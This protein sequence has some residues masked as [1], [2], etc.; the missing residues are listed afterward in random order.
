MATVDAA[1][2]WLSLDGRVLAFEEHTARFARAVEF[3]GGDADAARAAM[4]EAREAT[5]DSGAFFPRVDFAEGTFTHRIRPNPQ[6]SESAV[7][8]TAPT[9]PRTMPAVKGP[10]LSA[11]AALNEQ[12]R[13]AG[14][15]E[16]VLLSF[17]GELIEA[18]FSALCWWRG[19]TLCYPDEDLERIDSVTW[20]TVRR[21]AIADGIPMSPELAVPADLAGTEVWVMNARH[22]IRAVTSWVDGPTL[23]SPTRAA[24]WRTRLHGLREGV[25]R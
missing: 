22:G 1:D 2:S 14:A 8:W 15:T 16:A 11:L 7:L 20:R 19:E 25:R 18:A 5:P 12:A 3:C 13:D 10:D 23:A 21:L 9:D 17:E 4:S 24:D 6:L